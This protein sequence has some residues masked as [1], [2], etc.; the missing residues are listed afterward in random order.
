MWCCRGQYKVM[1]KVF[2]PLIQSMY[3]FVFPLPC[4]VFCVSSLSALPCHLALRDNGLK[5]TSANRGELVD[6]DRSGAGV[7]RGRVLLIPQIGYAE[8][9]EETAESSGSRAVAVAVT[10]A[11]IR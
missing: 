2:Y 5:L 9:M 4:F 7:H 10:V 11:V 3:D 1:V 6:E 8:R